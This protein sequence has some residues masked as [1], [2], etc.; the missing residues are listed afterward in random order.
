MTT[1]TAVSRGAEQGT[2]DRQNTLAGTG[3]LVR[4]MLRRDRIRIPVWMAVIVLLTLSVNGSWEETYGTAGELREIAQTLDS[5]AMIAMAGVNYAGVEATTY[6]ALMG[7][8]MFWSTLIAVGIMSILLLVRHTRAEEEANR[9]ELVRANVVGRHAYLT[10]AL[11]VVGIANLG[12]GLLMA[13]GLGAMGVPTI[14]WPGSWLYG[15]GHVV[16][17]M[18]FAAVAAV[19]VQITEYSRGAAGMAF[20][21]LGAAYALRAMGDVGENVLNWFSPLGWAQETR[22]YVEDRWWPLLFVVVAVV[23]AGVAYH[24]STR[25]DVGS[26]LRASRAGTPVA[27]RALVT[28]IGFAMRLHRGLMIGFGVAVA[29][30]GLAYGSVLG[31]AEQLVEDLDA[32]QDMLEGMA[33]SAIE[34]FG[35]TILT[36]MALIA[37]IYVVLAMQRPRGE[38]TSGRAEPVLSTAASRTRWLGSHVAVAI[39]GSVVMLLAIAVA[40]GAAGAASVG[41]GELFGRLATGALAYVPALWLTIGVAV[42]LLGWLPRAVVL[43]WVI[44][45]YGIIVIYLGGLFQFPDWLNNLSP[46]GHVPQMPSDDF[47]LTPLLILTAVAAVLIALGLYGFRQRDLDVK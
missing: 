9:A 23:L 13:V 32:Y 4:F 11:T 22:V 28:P 30:L 20:G 46:F 40:F 25:R 37:S 31:S 38:E 39:G 19:T 8:Q 1:S 3:M 6:G 2:P 18:A 12:I 43:T 14:D 26:G 15:A 45:V 35:A 21:V 29:L 24:L 41:E 7:Q 17:G 27:S 44:P 42:A 16:V 34:A 47:R 36:I 5:P 10:A 33:G